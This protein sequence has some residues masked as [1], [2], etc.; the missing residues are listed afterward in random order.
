M[1]FVFRASPLG[2]RSDYVAAAAALA[3]SAVTGYIVYRNVSRWYAEGW[4]RDTASVHIGVQPGGYGYEVEAGSLDRS[5][6]V[7]EEVC[8]EGPGA[9]GAPTAASSSARARGHCGG[10]RRVAKR[11]RVVPEPYVGG[12]LRSAYLAE[13]IA[14]VRTEPYAKSRNA[15]NVRHVEA[16]LKRRMVEHGVRPTHIDEKMPVLVIMC[17]YVTDRQADI[18]R[19]L[20]ALDDSLLLVPKEA[21]RR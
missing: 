6:E 11:L 4:L 16:H 15:D 19:K 18:A 13:L 1:A 20:A 10:S 21:P 12:V 14:E 9:N 7:T 8:G 17:F 3:C 2:T 5:Y